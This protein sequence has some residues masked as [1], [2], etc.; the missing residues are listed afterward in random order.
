MQKTLLALNRAHPGNELARFAPG[1]AQ[2]VFA[3][4]RVEPVENGAPRAG[5]QMAFE[6]L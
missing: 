5:L 1:H 3:H 2:Q 4:E 6:A